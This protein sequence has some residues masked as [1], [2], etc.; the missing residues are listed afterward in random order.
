[1]IFAQ[2]LYPEARRQ[3][4]DHYNDMT[5]STQA[6]SFRAVWLIM[7]VLLLA[8][9]LRIVNAGHFGV[10]TDEG[11]S[12]WAAS[13]HNFGVIIDT[14]LAKDRHPP[15][16]E[17]MLSGWWTIAGDSRIALRFLAIAGGLITVAALYRLVTDIFGRR[18]AI[19]AALLL[20]ILP[21]AVYYS[22]EI[23]DYG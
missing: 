5:E 7:L 13:D 17:L 19:Y 14:V 10:W 20:S 4:S 8:A 3:G 12:T 2:T 15:L 6:L 23:R 22:Q 18:A 1:M 11:W 16:F 9:G 21:S